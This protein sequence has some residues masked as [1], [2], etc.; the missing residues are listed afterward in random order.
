MIPRGISF[1]RSSLGG[2]ADLSLAKSPFDLL[3][4]AGGDT[5]SSSPSGEADARVASCKRVMEREGP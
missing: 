2:I 5:S 4:M 1:S 3:L